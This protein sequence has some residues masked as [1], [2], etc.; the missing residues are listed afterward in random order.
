MSAMETDDAVLVCPSFAGLATASQ[1][2]GA[3]RVLLA[4]YRFVD[5]PNPTTP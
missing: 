5:H 3:G 4:D 1:L 2:T